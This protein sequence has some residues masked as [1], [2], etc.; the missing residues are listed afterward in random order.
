MH[1]SDIP[2]SNTCRFVVAALVLLLV[3]DLLPEHGRHL[4]VRQRPSALLR[5][6]GVDRLQAGVRKLHEQGLLSVGW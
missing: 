6:L 1:N 2:A 3:D 4:L 5:H